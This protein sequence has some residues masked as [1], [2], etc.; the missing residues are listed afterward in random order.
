MEDFETRQRFEMDECLVADSRLG[1]P[2]CFQ[3]GQVFQGFQMFIANRRAIESQAGQA[4]TASQRGD[5]C[6]IDRCVA[7]PKRR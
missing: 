5:R 1:N 3:I 4:G 6:R 2:E 7:Q